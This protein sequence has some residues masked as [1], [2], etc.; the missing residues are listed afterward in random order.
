[1]QKVQETWFSLRSLAVSDSDTTA[2]L[3]QDPTESETGQHTYRTRVWRCCRSGFKIGSSLVTLAVVIVLIVVAVDLKTRMDVNEES[4]TRLKHVMKVEEKSFTDY[5]SN[6]KIHNSS[7]KT[8]QEVKSTEEPHLVQEDPAE[9]QQLKRESVAQKLAL[10]LLARKLN[11]T[12]LALDLVFQEANLT[13]CSQKSGEGV[14]APSSGTYRLEYSASILEPVGLV[15]SFGLIGSLMISGFP[16]GEGG[17][18]A[19]RGEGG[20]R[21][22]A[23]GG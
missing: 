5:L 19:E 21:R 2:I 3:G 10:D 18:P 12:K 14:V 13:L 17:R 4:L 6:N 9:V 15:V 23:E 20:G 8:K 16:W 11:V 1:M 22:C 7:E